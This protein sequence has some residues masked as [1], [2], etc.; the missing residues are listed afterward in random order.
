[1]SGEKKGKAWK[2]LALISVA[3]ILVLT[4]MGTKLK[5]IFKSI[6]DKLGNAAENANKINQ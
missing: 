3:V 6:A 5:E 1:M 4:T 2:I